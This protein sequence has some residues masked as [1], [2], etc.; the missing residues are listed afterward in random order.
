M[1]YNYFE[2]GCFSDDFEVFS[3]L[4]GLFQNLQLVQN[5]PVTYPTATGTAKSSTAGQTLS[6]TATEPCPFVEAVKQMRHHLFNLHN[7]HDI[8][9]DVLKLDNDKLRLWHASYKVKKDVVSRII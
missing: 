3:P 5:L 1:A 7:Q 8:F 9:G 2:D 4:P 6:S